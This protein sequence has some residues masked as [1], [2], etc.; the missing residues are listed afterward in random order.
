MP[1]YLKQLL[2]LFCILL[3]VSP[4]YAVSKLDY[5]EALLAWSKVL[6][7]YVDE[8]GRIDFITLVKHPEDLKQ[9]VHF[10]AR[11]SPLS[12]PGLFPSKQAVL[13]YH[14]NAYNA[15]AMYN[16]IATGV[17]TGFNYFAKRF[18]FF[19][20]IKVFIGGDMTSLYD[21][22]NNVIRKLGEP[23][24]HFAL[25]CMVRDCPRL[26]RKVFVAETLEQ[27]L[28]QLSQEFFNNQKH[29]RIDHE[30]KIVYV[31]EIL[32]FYTE[33]FVASGK[34]QDLIAYINQF[35]TIAIP[36]DYQLKFI[37]YDWTVNQQP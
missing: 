14:I 37:D 12:H 8:Q 15:S 21:Y 24:I 22:E 18:W 5:Q 11:V 16:V 29:L 33:D 35:R 23:R 31:S 26:P 4:S 2:V 3:I 36:N 13:A 6:T 19:K 27:D 28:S 7:E 30:Q 17:P 9:F 32:D 34:S 1:F 10:I 20:S 25:N